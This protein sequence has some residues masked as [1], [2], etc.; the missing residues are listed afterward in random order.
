VSIV[1]GEMLDQ[2]AGERGQR[3][4]EVVARS[5]PAIAIYGFHR[6]SAEVGAGPNLILAYPKPPKPNLEA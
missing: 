6:G 2:D 3:A 4:A 1:P 5:M